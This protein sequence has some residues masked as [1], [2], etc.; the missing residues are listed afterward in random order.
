MYHEIGALRPPTGLM[1]RFASVYMHATDHAA[2]NR[3]HFY[4][5]LREDLLRLLSD[6]LH[7]NNKLVKFFT[8]IRDLIESKKVPEVVKF[9]M[10]A[11]EGRQTGHTC[12]Y[13]SPEPSE[14]AALVVG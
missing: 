12:E 11:H 5:E 10:H 14:F 3:K 2:S 13:N 4:G 7:Q 1:P 6:M 9:V 8:S